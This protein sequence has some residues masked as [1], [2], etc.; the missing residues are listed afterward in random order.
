MLILKGHFGVLHVFNPL[1][2]S[3]LI[4]MLFSVWPDIMW[5]LSLGILKV[6]G[7]DDDSNFDIVEETPPVPDI[8]SLKPSKEFRYAFQVNH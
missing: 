3:D 4:L 6:S 8:A 7:A 2:I 5:R 1:K